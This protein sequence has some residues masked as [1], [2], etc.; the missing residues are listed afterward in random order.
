VL[1]AAYY[2]WTPFSARA[3]ERGGLRGAVVLYVVVAGILWNLLLTTYSMVGIAVVAA[4]IG[5]LALFVLVLAYGISAVGRRPA[6]P[7]PA[8]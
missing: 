2:S 8:G 1:A 3:N 5:L 6:E 4:N 7:S